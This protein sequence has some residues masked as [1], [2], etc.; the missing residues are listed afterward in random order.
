MSVSFV[1]YRT[2]TA[3]HFLL[4][5]RR[6]CK[7]SADL[8]M[9]IKERVGGNRLQLDEKMTPYL[10]IRLLDFCDTVYPSHRGISL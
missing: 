1:F 7:R 4:L 3:P 8:A 9:I 6:V 10:Q 5:S 2:N